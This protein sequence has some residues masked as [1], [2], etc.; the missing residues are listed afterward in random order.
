[1]AETYNLNMKIKKLGHCC[2]LIKTEKATILTDP[3]NY[4]TLQ[5][6]VTGIDVILITHEHQDHF[7]LESLKKV[8][9][10]N[11]SAKIITNASIGKLL[12]EQKISFEI[13]SEGQSNDTYGVLIEG[14]GHEHA[15]IYKTWG[16]VENTGYF[17]DGKLFYPG[18][19]FTDPHRPVDVLALPVA[20]PWMKISEALEY[21]LV[22]KP[23]A[24]FPVHDGILKQAGLVHRAPAKIFLENGIEFI[25]LLEGDEK[26]F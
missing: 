25:P 12:E 22:L 10:N 7:H 20:G 11:P 24:V 8:L 13:V 18:D 6:D 4:S 2:L 14:Y 15:E 23:R 21:G 16:R 9:E 19:A 17:I 1:M 5:N 26:E 3:G